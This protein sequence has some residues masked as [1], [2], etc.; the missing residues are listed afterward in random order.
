VKSLVIYSAVAG[1]RDFHPTFEPA[2]LAAVLRAADLVLFTSEKDLIAY[3]AKHKS[4]WRVR[5]LPKDFP[6]PARAAKEVKLAP[7]RF[8]ADHETSLWL[9]ANMRLISD[10]VPIIARELAGAAFAAYAHSEKLQGLYHEASRCI[11]MKKG[12]RADLERQIQAYR[13]EGL[14]ERCRM[15][16]CGLLVRRHMDP[17]VVA[18]DD[19]WWQQV[20]D[21]S[22][23]DQVGFPYAFWKTGLAWKA[24]QTPMRQ[25]A[26]I[27]SH[28]R[29]ATQP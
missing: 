15:A 1:P 6:D 27:G 16:A 26:V 24:I 28:A 9:D 22:T 29:R 23:R 17:A 4:P 20:R 13:N 25:W 21:Y 12:L 19:I 10:P 7:H 11:E 8:L 14:P 3:C 2:V 5:E 18:F